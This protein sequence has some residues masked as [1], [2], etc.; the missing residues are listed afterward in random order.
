MKTG[1]GWWALAGIVVPTLLLGLYVG[2][3]FA[4]VRNVKWAP[5]Y[6]RP[7]HAIAEPVFRP[8]H[9]IDRKWLRPRE[10][11]DLWDLR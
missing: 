10:W 11:D 1:R 9:E 7:I 3:Y 4:M 8:I 2:A 6:P 5:Q